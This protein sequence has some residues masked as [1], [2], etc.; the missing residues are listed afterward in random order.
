MLAAHPSRKLFRPGFTPLGLVPSAYVGRALRARPTPAPPPPPRPIP[1]S[2]RRQE[3]MREPAHDEQRAD[4]NRLPP[5]MVSPRDLPAHAVPAATDETEDEDEHLAMVTRRAQ[6]VSL[7]RTS[8]SHTRFTSLATDIVADT[9]VEG[10]AAWQ[11]AKAGALAGDLHNGQDPRSIAW[12]TA[13]EKAVALW[14]AQAR[15]T[16]RDFTRTD[17]RAVF[18]EA[19]TVTYGAAAATFWHRRLSTGCQWQHR[20]PSRH[21]E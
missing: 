5:G 21:L 6:L 11:R 12:H 9:S 20:L 17:L 8:L 10:A 13:I 18:R 15:L 4:H 19:V 2:V 1:A 16:W 7:L 3:R 14:T